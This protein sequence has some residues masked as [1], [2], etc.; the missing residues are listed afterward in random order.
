MTINSKEMLLTL[1]NGKVESIIS[2]CQMLLDQSQVSVRG[3]F[4]S[5]LGLFLQ[6]S[7]P[8]SSLLQGPTGSTY[9]YFIEQG[10]LPS[11][12]I[13]PRSGENGIRIVDAQFETE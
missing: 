1:P 11:Q 9:S 12:D 3:N 8:C 5:S 7:S 10:V 2:Q 13:S 6:R 4:Q